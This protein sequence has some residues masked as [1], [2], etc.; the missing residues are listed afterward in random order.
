MSIIFTQQPQTITSAYNPNVFSFSGSNVSENSYQFI[1]NIT[2]NN[3]TYPFTYPTRQGTALGVFNA[4][5]VIES[6]VTQDINLLGE[7]GFTVCSNS[8]VQ[9]VVTVGEQYIPSGSTILSSTTAIVTADTVTAINFSLDTL[10]FPDYDYTQYKLNN[11]VSSFLTNAPQTQSIGTGQHAFLHLI[12]SGYNVSCNSI[13]VKKYSSSNVLLGT[14]SFYNTYTGSSYNENFLR[15]AVGTADIED[16]LSANFLDN[17][18]YYT[19][20]AMDSGAT[21]VSKVMRYN[22]T[23]YDF[24]PI[25]FHFLN[26]KGGFDSFNFEC[27]RR[28]KMKIARTTYQRNINTFANG[29]YSYDKTSRGTVQATT[30]VENTFTVLSNWLTEDESTWLA[31]LV[32][33]PVIFIEEDGTFIPVT[34]SN[35][36]Y[37]PNKLYRNNPL[38]NLELD[39]AYSVSDSRQRY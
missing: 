39:V 9:Y 28:D 25:R 36:F 32:S 19:V 2:F 33:S 8:V 20:Q 11:F 10:E 15:V 31:E 18:S 14:E 35:D 38:F 17:A 24:D 27:R 7:T 4:Q 29:V 1:V 6:Q 16:T 5:K 12:T 26:K 37:E 13:Q 21:P 22:I 30:D 34:V 3:Q 23:C